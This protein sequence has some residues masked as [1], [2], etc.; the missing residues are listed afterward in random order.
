MGKPY[1]KERGL[2]IEVDDTVNIQMNKMGTK[3]Q[4]ETRYPTNKELKECPK[5]NLAGKNEWKP[6]SVSLGSAYSTR[7]QIQEPGFKEKLLATIKIKI[8]KTTIF[9]NALEDIPTRQ[10][11]YLTDRNYKISAEVLADRF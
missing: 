2:T 3:I 5:L 10:T 9:D 6:S 4:L 8:S 11:Y 7:Y 1:D